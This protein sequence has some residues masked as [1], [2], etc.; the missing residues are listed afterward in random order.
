VASV[1]LLWRRPGNVIG[2]LLG[3]VALAG[4]GSFILTWIAVV[5]ADHPASAVA[6]ALAPGALGSVLI[7]S[8]AAIL[9]LF[10]T[11]RPLPGMERTFSAFL[12]LAMLWTAVSTVRPGPMPITGRP[13]RLGS[14]ALAPVVATLEYA[15]WSSSRWRCGPWPSATAEA[16]HASV[17]SYG[18][19]SPLGCSSSPR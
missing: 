19:C 9:L 5:A 7:C 17:R 2:R 3:L 12:G 18:G 1:L 11:G 6:E 8:I 13:N 4:A 16:G 14:D 15:P 10:P